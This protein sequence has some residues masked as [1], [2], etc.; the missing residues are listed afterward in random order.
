MIKQKIF[1]YLSGPCPVVFPLAV[2]QEFSFS[3][4]MKEYIEVVREKVKKTCSN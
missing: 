2:A 3:A 1:E 4:K